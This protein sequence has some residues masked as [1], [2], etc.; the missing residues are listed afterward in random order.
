MTAQ[1]VENFLAEYRRLCEWYGLMIISGEHSRVAVIADEPKGALEA[2][3]DLLRDR[4]VLRGICKE[5]GQ[6]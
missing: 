6:P 3:A 2:E 4:D 5:T 1:H